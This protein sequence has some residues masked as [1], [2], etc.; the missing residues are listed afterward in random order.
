MSQKKSLTNRVA[1]SIYST[2]YGNSGYS[3]QTMRQMLLAKQAAKNVIRMIRE[4]NGPISPISSR[5]T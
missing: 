2:C 3:D 5:N 1:V 4:N